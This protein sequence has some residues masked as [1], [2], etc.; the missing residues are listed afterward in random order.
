[1]KDLPLI[2]VEELPGCQWVA[3]LERAIKAPATFE[4]WYKEPQRVINL[5]QDDFAR[6]YLGEFK[7]VEPCRAYD[8]QD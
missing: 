7:P 8:L 5:S 3:S 6:I 1:M 4:C 2:E